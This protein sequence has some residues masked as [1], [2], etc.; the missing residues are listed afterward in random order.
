MKQKSAQQ[1]AIAGA[2]GQVFSSQMQKENT[3]LSA[4]LSQENALFQNT[5][6][7]SNAQYQTIGDKVYKVQ[8]G[9]MVD[10]GIRAEK[11]AQYQAYGGKLYKVKGDSVTEVP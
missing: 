6:N 5:L 10:T 3:L 1:Q 2:A 4:K 7:Q 8:N 11:D 9:E